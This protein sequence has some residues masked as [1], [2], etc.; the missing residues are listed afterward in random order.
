MADRCQRAHP[1]GQ[2]WAVPTHSNTRP[3]SPHAGRCS[4]GIHSTSSR[5]R[6]RTPDRI[7]EPVAGGRT[8]RTHRSD[9]S[10]ARSRVGRHGSRL[11]SG[12]QRAGQARPV[13][14][15][16]YASM[17]MKS[18]QQQVVEIQLRGSAAFWLPPRS[19]SDGT[20]RFLAHWSSCRWT[21]PRVVS[22]ASRMPENGIHPAQ[23]PVTVEVLRDYRCG[24]RSIPSTRRTIHSQA[25]RIMNSHSPDVVGELAADEVIFID[26]VVR[27]QRR[28]S[29]ALL[30]LGRRARGDQSHVTSSPVTN[31]SAWKLGAPRYRDRPADALP[32]VNRA[33]NRYVVLGDGR[34]D[35]ALLPIVEWAIDSIDSSLPLGGA[36]RAAPRANLKGGRKRSRP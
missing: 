28:R 18:R 36:L 3:W 7:G 11:R 23:V 10:P 5:A 17:S 6:L 33:N 27:T 25:G 21:H 15:A 32:Y 2:S 9:A 8:R 35:A 4:P 19:L 24:P 12:R 20:L 31:W 1:Q 16:P 34:S 22:C 29:K 13:G 14:P 26:T 30:R